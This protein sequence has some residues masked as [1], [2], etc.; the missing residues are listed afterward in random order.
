MFSFWYLCEFLIIIMSTV[1]Y[2]KFELK[3][4][5]KL[6]IVGRYYYYWYIL[7]K[8]IEC[9]SRLGCSTSSCPFVSIYIFHDT[10]RFLN[11]VSFHLYSC[12]TRTNEYNKIPCIPIDTVTWI[13]SKIHTYSLK[14]WWRKFWGTNL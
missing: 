4:K 1:I 7:L 3:I 10:D 11:C 12:I 2:L 13:K 8:F 5:L 6:K 14:K 9:R